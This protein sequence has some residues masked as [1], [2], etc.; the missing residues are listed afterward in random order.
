GYDAA[1]GN[2]DTANQDHEELPQAQG[3]DNR[4]LGQEVLKIAHRNKMRGKQAECHDQGYE[5]YDRPGLQKP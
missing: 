5:N 3:A 2:I 1:D 4:A